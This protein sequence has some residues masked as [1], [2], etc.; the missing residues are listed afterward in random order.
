MI[1]AGELIPPL[2]NLM[3]EQLFAYDILQ[4]DGTTVQ[5]LKEPG[6]TA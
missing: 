5:V 4:M 3:H 1:P 6:K 2:I